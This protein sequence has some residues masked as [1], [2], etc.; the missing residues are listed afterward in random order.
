MDSLS[1]DVLLIIANYLDISSYISLS[2][3]SVHFNV[4]NQ[5]SVWKTRYERSFRCLWGQDQTSN[6]KEDWYTKY[7]QA[8]VNRKSIAV[9]YAYDSFYDR[10]GKLGSQKIPPYLF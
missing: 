1:T 9:I 8:H 2:N 4:L 3:T 6:T 10:N 7:K 5:L